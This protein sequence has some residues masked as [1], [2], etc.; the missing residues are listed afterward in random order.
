M[1]PLMKRL[2]ES[3][4]LRAPLTYARLLRFK[5]NWNLDKYL[6]LSLAR[7]GNVV[8]DGGANVGH[9]SLLFSRIVGPRGKVFSFEPAPPTFAQLEKNLFDSG[10]KNVCAYAFALGHE[11]GQATIH[12]PNGVSGHA[13]IAPHFDAWGDIPVEP[14]EIEVRRL[15]AW[16]EEIGLDCLDFVKLDLEG[17]EPLAIEGASATLR[18]HLPSMH[19]E[20]SPGFMKDFGRSVEDLQKSLEAIGYDT[21]LSFRDKNEP[22]TYLNELVHE[23]PASLD[24]TLVCLNHEKHA[25]QLAR[26]V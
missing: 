8:L 5:E 3:V 13:A 25:K 23:K 17:A 22:P 2:L 12:L 15:D 14:Y 24:C 18:R 10:T 6:F 20:L 11:S 21:L 4:L 1:A 19:L 16:A 26:L 7:A 9:Y